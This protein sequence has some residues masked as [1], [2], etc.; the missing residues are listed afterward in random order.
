MEGNE[1]YLDPLTAKRLFGDLIP[2]Q[3]DENARALT[4]HGGR[5]GG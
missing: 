5:V 2:Y 4:A 3:N 1:R